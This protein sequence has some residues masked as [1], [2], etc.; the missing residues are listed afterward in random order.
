MMMTMMMMMG[1]KEELVSLVERDPVAVANN[2]DWV[3]EVR[4]MG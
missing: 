2:L 1:S 4:I 3:Q